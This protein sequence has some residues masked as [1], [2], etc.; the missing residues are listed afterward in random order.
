MFDFR[1]VWDKL[2]GK[3]TYISGALMIILSGL[4]AQGY[5]TKDQYELLLGIFVAFGIISL[6]HGVSKLE[7]NGK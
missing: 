1:V 2:S 7:K 5:I 6:R 4:L 3:K